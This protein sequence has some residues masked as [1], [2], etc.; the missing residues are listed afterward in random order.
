MASLLSSPLDRMGKEERYRYVCRVK[1]RVRLVT[2]CHFSF[3]VGGVRI[4]GVVVW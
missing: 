1:G 3:K 2:G 4:K